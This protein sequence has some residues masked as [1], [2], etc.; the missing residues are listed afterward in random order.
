MDGDPSERAATTGPSS[1][2]PSS[3]YCASRGLGRKLKRRGRTHVNLVLLHVPESQEL[4]EVLGVGDESVRANHL[5]VQSSNEGVR[6]LN[7]NLLG[8]NQAL[9]STKN[10]VGCLSKALGL[11]RNAKLVL[12]ALVLLAQRTLSVD[13]VDLQSS[14]GSAGCS[15]QACLQNCQSVSVISSS[16]TYGRLWRRDSGADQC[17]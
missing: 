5:W 9:D 13:Q 15:P 12:G 11:D 1:L 3:W 7:R 17:Q 4:V 6:V 16:I 14:A 2:S 8:P 10:N